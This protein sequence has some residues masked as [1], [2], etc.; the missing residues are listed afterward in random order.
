MSK[1]GFCS[2]AGCKNKHISKGFCHAHYYR[3]KHGLDLKTPIKRVKGGTINDAGYKLVYVRERKKQILEHRV[4]MEKFI[5]RKLN[6]LDVVHH[7]NGI[8]NDNRIENLEIIPW[9][10]HTSI[11]HKGIPKISMRGRKKN[12]HTGKFL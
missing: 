6:R 3:K 10:Q 7:K 4:I 11:H 8:K 2:V 5:K 1:T 12:R 9:G